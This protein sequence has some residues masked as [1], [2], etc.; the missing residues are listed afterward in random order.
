MEFEKKRICELVD[1][2]PDCGPS[3]RELLS[4]YTRRGWR[5]IDVINELHTDPATPSRYL[6]VILEQTQ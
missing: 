6:M 5:I 2:R 3:P 1:I 4:E